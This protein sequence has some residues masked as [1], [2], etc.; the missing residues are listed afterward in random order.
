VF[1]Y[2]KRAD[3]ARPDRFTIMKA[4]YDKNGPSPSNL[5]YGYVRRS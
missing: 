3:L 5:R 2:A 4:E 1:G